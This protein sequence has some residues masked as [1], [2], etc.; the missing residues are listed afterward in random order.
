MEKNMETPPLSQGTLFTIYW[1]YM[2][3]F[4]YY[5]MLNELYRGIYG[6]LQGL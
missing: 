1:G 2:G 4:V 3:I 6:V 5:M